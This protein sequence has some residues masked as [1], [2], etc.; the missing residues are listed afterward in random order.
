[1]QGV[2]K[3]CGKASGMDSSYR[4]RKKG[5]DNMGPEMYGYIVVQACIY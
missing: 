2:S 4:E 5:H 1:M 3:L